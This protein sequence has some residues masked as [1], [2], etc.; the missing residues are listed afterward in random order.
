MVKNDFIGLLLILTL[1]IGASIIVYRFINPSVC[2]A[3]CEPISQSVPAQKF[4]A[5]TKNITYTIIDVRTSQEFLD[6]HIERAVNAD[7]KDSAS[8]AR[9][10]DSLDT[11][12]KYLVYCRSGNRS[13][14]AADYM[15]QKGFM[16]VTNL[17]GGILNWQ[18]SGYTLVK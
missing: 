4:H 2:G 16:H 7:I 15:K 18:H 1:I 12:G 14:Q 11:S 5:L 9:Y 10:L 17:S 8:F 3:V 13:A 6:G